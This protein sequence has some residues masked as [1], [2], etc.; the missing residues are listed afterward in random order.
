MRNTP[1]DTVPDVEISGALVMDL[2]EI[3]A[4]AGYRA[5]DAEDT[6]SSEIAAAAKALSDEAVAAWMSQEELA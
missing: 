6:A 4:W 1:D 2:L 3:L 5:T